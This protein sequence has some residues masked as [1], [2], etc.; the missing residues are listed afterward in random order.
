MAIVEFNVKFP[1][2]KPNIANELLVAGSKADTSKISYQYIRIELGEYILDQFDI[3]YQLNLD[4][5]DSNSP[6][7]IEVGLG[8]NRLDDK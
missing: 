6:L 2:L 1:I 3:D 8:V 7:D 4:S 5:M